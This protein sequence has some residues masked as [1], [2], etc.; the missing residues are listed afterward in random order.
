MCDLA[1]L[2]RL[3]DGT[4][5]GDPRA[6]R[7]EV[8][9]G[10][11]A[12]AIEPHAHAFPEPLERH[13]VPRAATH[14]VSKAALLVGCAT[15]RANL[16]GA[17]GAGS[18]AGLGRRRE[19][20]EALAMSETRSDVKAESNKKAV[21]AGVATAAVVTLGVLHAPIFITGLVAVPAVLLGHRW[22]KHRAENGIR[23]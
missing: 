3:A 6:P 18:S 1:A 11:L 2:P 16:Y 17:R 8:R 21:R 15:Q 10:G 13:R 5:R 7:V 12:I 22:W 4:A 19:L 20:C 23:F 9:D 14:E